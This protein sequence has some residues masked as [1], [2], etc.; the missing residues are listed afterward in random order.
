MICCSAYVSDTDGLSHRITPV[1]Q[2]TM[3]TSASNALETLGAG[4]PITEN[5]R[6]VTLATGSAVAMR[7]SMEL[8]ART[9]SQDDMESTAPLVSVFFP[10]CHKGASDLTN[11]SWFPEALT[12]L[13]KFTLYTTRC[14]HFTVAIFINESEMFK[15]STH[16]ARAHGV[17]I[18]ANSS[19]DNTVWH[20]SW[21]CFLLTHF[22]N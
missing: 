22:T 17:S 10:V 5:A 14:L 6:T 3:D 1:V 18:V 15:F 13:T 16:L 9:V 4:A 11:R 7:V 21:N 19:I 8:H 2:V 20:T 12:Y